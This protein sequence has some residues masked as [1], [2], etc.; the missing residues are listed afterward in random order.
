VAQASLDR[1]APFFSDRLF[2]MST[3]GGGPLSPSHEL[4]RG[5][6]LDRAARRYRSAVRRVL[7]YGRSAESALGPLSRGERVENALANA[8]TVYAAAVT[9]AAAL[10]RSQIQTWDVASGPM[11]GDQIVDVDGRPLAWH[12]LVAL[13][14]VIL[15]RERV[16]TVGTMVEI[17]SGT[18]EFARL[19]IATG[20][21]RR[22][23]LV[24]IPPALAFAEELVGDALGG[25]AIDGFISGREQ[26]DQGGDG[27]R[28]TF[29]TPD[30]LR[31]VPRADVVVNVASFGEMPRPVVL[32]YMRELK[33][34][35][36][37]AILSV[38]VARP[39]P[40]NAAAGIGSE[41][42]VTELAPEYTPAERAA[43]TRTIEAELRPVPSGYGGYEWILFRR[44]GAG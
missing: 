15:L 36:P 8:R 18:G 26:V 30:Q 21:A 34:L 38:N 44:A 22:C 12:T 9:A 4:I 27:V 25:A 16:G 40:L 2:L 14:R 32:G 41:L 10:F 23:V 29:V 20:T 42:Y 28:C 33:R 11:F 43:W 17:G 39:H 6:L 37:E 24:D 3:F 1:N 19:M 13:K 35:R 5:S 7:G 31:H